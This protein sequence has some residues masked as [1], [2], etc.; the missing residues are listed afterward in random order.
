MA[1][2]FP[3]WCR[4]RD[5]FKQTEPRRSCKLS[6]STAAPSTALPWP[7]D[8]PEARKSGLSWQREAGEEACCEPRR[9]LSCCALEV[10]PSFRV[11][12][13]LEG[14]ESFH[15]HTPKHWPLPA[16]ELLWVRACPAR[17]FGG[18]WG[19][20]G[21]TGP[22]SSPNSARIEPGHGCLLRAGRAVLLTSASFQIFLPYLDEMH[23][24]SNERLF[25]ALI[26]WSSSWLY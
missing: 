9:W 15:T 16:P 3:G 13:C 11:P 21:R 17:G 18:Q 6:R 5:T 2:L 23:Y 20:Q 25:R 8:S 1:P 26:P 19:S 7:G 10:H 24:F 12:M 4:N 22:S 14:Q